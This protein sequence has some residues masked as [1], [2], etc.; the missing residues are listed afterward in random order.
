MAKNALVAKYL[1][2]ISMLEKRTL[3][4]QD[5]ARE[6]EKEL[7]EYLEVRKLST[8]ILISL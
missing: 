5:K 3:D 4:I 2:E 6:E 7:N 1:P 8:R